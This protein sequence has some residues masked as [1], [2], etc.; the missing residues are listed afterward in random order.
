LEKHSVWQDITEI[1][2]L[3]VSLDLMVTFL[4]NHFK[5]KFQKWTGALKRHAGRG[6]LQNYVTPKV[7]WMPVS[8]G[9]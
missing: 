1:M 9:C 7:N 4:G 8:G 5:K 3:F 2:K 6:L